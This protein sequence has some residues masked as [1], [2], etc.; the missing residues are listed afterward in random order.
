VVSSGKWFSELITPDM[1]LRYRVK[2]TLYSGKTD[3]QQID[4]LETDTLGKSLILDGKTQST[5]VD[6]HIYHETLVHPPMLLH[7]NPKS[8]FIGGGG[9]GATLREV[10]LH[11][12]VERVVMVD[13]DPQVVQLCR[14]YLPA[15]SSGAFDDPRLELWHQD[16]RGYLVDCQESFDVIVL[17]LVDPLEGGTAYTLY[18]RE[19]YEIACAKLNPGGLLVTQSGPASLLNFTEC[20]TPIVNTLSSLSWRVLPYS[21]YV[22]SFVTLWGFTIAFS[23]SGPLNYAPSEMD[24]LINQRLIAQPRFYDGITHQGMFSLPSFLRKGIDR[25]QRVITDGEPVFMI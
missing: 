21:V 5:E 11:N 18:T 13:L 15:H 20:F 17:D 6:E 10:L 1:L 25:E 8:V 16:A 23:G 12:S 3:Y 4:I 22:P 2:Q 7:T 14:E 24:Q 19:F 9:E